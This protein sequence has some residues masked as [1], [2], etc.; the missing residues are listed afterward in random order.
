[1][2]RSRLAACLLALA[3][4]ASSIPHATA[5][6][7]SHAVDYDV[8]YVRAPRYGDDKATKWP[9][10]K[11]PIQME[12]G[13][14]LMLLHPDGSEEVL[15]KGGN[16]SVVD[17][18][19]SFD[20]QS[21]YYSYF[22]DQRPEALNGQR[23]NASRAG[24]DIYRIHLKTREIV[25][26]TH[27]EFTPNTGVTNW[28]PNPVKPEEAGQTYLGYGVFNLGPCPLPG[29]RVI[30]TSSRNGFLPN[31]GYTFPNLQ[32]FVMD[33]DGSN[34]EHIGHLN[35]GSAL[36]P[37]VLLDGR[38]M[39]SSYEAQGIRDQRLWG[40]WAI[41]PDGT[42]WEPL[43]SAFSDATAFHFQTQLSK[44]EVVVEHY[45][46]Q[47][48]NGF[49]SFWTLPAKPPA[50]V[51]P[52]GSPNPR[53]PSN[54]LFR[55]GRHGNG[56]PRLTTV[57]FSPR[58][59][60]GLTAFTWGVDQASPRDE[61]GSWMGKV[62]HPAAAPNNDLLLVWSGGPAND[63]SRP[64]RTPYYDGGLYRL[65]GGSKVESH[66]D[67]Q[68]IKN[69]PKYNE[70]QPRPVVRFR[71][72]YGV[73]EPATIEPLANDGSQSP[74]LPEGTPFGIIGTSSFFKRNT[75]PGTGSAKFDGLDPFNTSENGASSNWNTQGADAGKYTNEDIFAVRILSM[76]PTSH[77]SYGDPTGYRSFSNHANERLR[78]L[79]EIPLRKTDKSGREILD[80]EGNPDTSFAAKIPADVPF[81]FQTLDQNGH[82]LNMSQTWHQ[83]RPGE[84]RYNCGGC[85]AHAQKGLDFSQTFAAKDEYKTVD[86]SHAAQLL[87]PAES[88]T[89][90]AEIAHASA[91]AVD[92]EYY[93]DIK[94]IFAR[95]CVKCHSKDG[96]AKAGLVLD[97]DEIVGGFEN[98]YHRLANDSRAT[99]GR[100][101]VIKNGQW[102]QTN[103]SR[104]IR[105]FQSRRSL[106]TWKVYGKRLDGWSNDD[107]P[108]ESIPGDAST[109][110]EGA[111]PND[112]DID[113]VGSIMPPAKSGV[114]ALTAEEKLT[115]ARWIDLGCPISRAAGE[116][117]QG[118]FLDE[119]RPTLTL[120]SPR[121]GDNGPIGKIILGAHDYYS[122]LEE[123][124]LLVTADFEIDGL[125]AGQ[126]LAARFEK[127]HDGVFEWK[128]KQPL[129]SLRQGTLT[130]SVKDRQGNTA[131]VIRTISIKTATAGRSPSRS[132]LKK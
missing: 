83:L 60:D 19:V 27:Q 34:V 10:V 76:E 78:I 124:S 5:E 114:P 62:T 2:R 7:P 126:N 37:T 35:L 30:F 74:A 92:V 49:G 9:E 91:G 53:D 13:A 96:D 107:H 127:S 56:K 81:T 8:V 64:V 51:A 117:G 86:L 12:P 52:F 31:K 4:F 122:G 6:Q 82:V 57:A 120:T 99:Y 32:L 97:D 33:D 14:D 44:G 132:P 95:S 3:V 24:A 75:T 67:L 77:L 72:V 69:D 116:E 36:H 106:L 131:Q 38:V 111:N 102:R 61:D 93:R 68:L 98:T 11:D 42:E 113:F 26:L 17:P 20:G 25:R 15:V 58:G 43:V 18:Y 1:M 89:R 48:N 39:F 70:M 66:R 65:H 100:K 59:L 50:G 94:P 21:V 105:Q 73:D 129:T 109:L 80:P 125:A 90:N 101:P 22:H 115:I 123:K 85:H 16:G 29:G 40:L 128:L 118:W 45:Y 41:R 71:D 28:S 23:R 47:N 130:V 79:G 87:K 88:E 46:N 54:V 55:Q 104:Y 119:L 84:V 63:L 110:P 121:R 108:T 112:A 103:A